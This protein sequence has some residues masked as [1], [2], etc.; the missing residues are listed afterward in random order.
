MSLESNALTTL[1][2]ATAWLNTEAADDAKIERLINVASARIEQ[3]TG[4]KFAKQVHSETHA[5]HGYQ[6]L[7]LDQ[8]PIIT[9]GT[10]PGVT[11]NDGAYTIGDDNDFVVVENEARGEHYLYSENGWPETK[12]YREG[13]LCPEDPD[14]NQKDRNIDVS[15]LAGYVL[16]EFVSKKVTGPIAAGALEIIT[17]S[18]TTCLAVGDT[19]TLTST[20]ATGPTV[21]AA[22]ESCTISAIPSS[23]TVT[24]ANVANAHA[25]TI[26]L[27]TTRTLPFDLEQNC[28]ELVEFLWNRR[29]AAG[30]KNEKT[31]GGQQIDYIDGMPADLYRR[32]IAYRRPSL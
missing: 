11:V 5:G 26:T 30:I 22:T 12:Y 8:W 15:N 2:N 32:I 21:A 13:T 31:A 27:T 4:R 23:T 29:G 25:G 14:S 16:P 20:G 1:A 6:N 3:I 19:T 10:Y 24:L 18:N 9:Q 28:I 7:Y 17:V